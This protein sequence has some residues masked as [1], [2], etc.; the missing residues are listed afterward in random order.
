MRGPL[1]F[2]LNPARHPQPGQLDL[3]NLALDPDSLEV[4]VTNEPMIRARGWS[5][6]RDY[7]I[8]PPDLDLE[9]TEYP[10]P[11]IEAVYFKVP[12]PKA[13]AFVDDELTTP[14]SWPTASATSPAFR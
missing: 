3:R 11:G 8:Q 1:V 4:A 10:D 14:G 7:A 6:G 12:D 2:G 9:L 13:V 5:F